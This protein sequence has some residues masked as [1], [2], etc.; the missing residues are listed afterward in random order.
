[1]IKYDNKVINDII[2]KKSTI[3]PNN[4]FIEIINNLK[5]QIKISKYEFNYD[6]KNTNNNNNSNNNNSNNSN[7]NNSNHS[8]NSNNNNSN[9]VIIIIVIIKY[10]KI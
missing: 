5:E 8:N 10:L 3:I 6:S 2:F 9:L 7:N 1:M 4:D